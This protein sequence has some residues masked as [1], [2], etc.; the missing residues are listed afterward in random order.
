MNR[1]A[2]EF[3]SLVFRAVLAFLMFAGSSQAQAQ[4]CSDSTVA[5]TFIDWT[6]GANGGAPA[7][8]CGALN[9]CYCPALDGAPVTE[10]I[11][12]NCDAT[13]QSCTVRVSVP[14]L[15]PGNEFNDASHET[16]IY[17]FRGATPSSCTFIPNVN[18]TAISICGSVLGG[19]LGASPIETSRGTAY[20]QVS[21]SCSTVDSLAAAGFYSFNA[22]TC[23][24]NGS[25]AAASCAS[26]QACSERRLDVPSLDLTVAA[27]K[28]ALKCAIPPPDNCAEESGG[29]SLL[30]QLAGGG[31]GKRPSAGAA[32]DS[33]KDCVRTSGPA[34]CGQGIFGRGPS[35]TPQGSGPGALLRYHAN[36]VGATG[37][38]GSAA[39]K[40]RL[41]RNWSHDFAERIVIDPDVN[42]VW[43]LTRYGTFREF[44][45]TGGG[46][47]TF[48]YPVANNSPSDEYR[49]LVVTTN[50]SGG[51]TAWELKG[52]D[53]T[54]QFFRG[55]GTWDRT[56]DRN[57]NTWQ[58]HYDDAANPTKLTRVI[59]PDKRRERFEY[60]ALSGK[61]ERIFEDG[62]NLV[63]T[64]QWVYSWSGDDLVSILRPDGTSWQFFYADSS[65]PGF[66]TR[67]DLVGTD[68]TSRRIESTFE[69]DTLGNTTAL[70]R[71]EIACTGPS[72]GSPVDKLT[73]AYTNPTLPTQTVVTHFLTHDAPPVTMPVTYTIERDPRSI[74]AR[75]KSMSGDCG[76][77]GLSPNT[78]FDYN[79]PANPLK[80]TA[81]TDGNTNRTEYTYA[82]NGMTL[83]KT[84]AKGTA[85]QRTTTWTYGSANFPA[86]PTLTTSPSSDDI[87]GHLRST[88]FELDPAKG[89]LTKRTIDGYEGGVPFP[90]AVR[91]TV[92]GYDPTSG[93]L[94]SIDPP[95]F[96]AS[97]ATTTAYDEDRGSLIPLTREDPVV[98]TT[99]FVHDDWNRQIRVIDPNAVVTDTVYD[100]LNRVVS[101]AQRALDSGA[102]DA[103]DLV[104]TYHY[105]CPAGTPEDGALPCRTFRDLRC[106]QLP[107]G[108]GIEYLYDAAGRQVQI[109]RKADC[110][111]ATQPFERTVFALDVSGNRTSESFEVREGSDWIV[112]SATQNLYTTTCHVD[113]TTRGIGSASPSTTE[114][115]YDRNNNL[116]M[117]WD[118]NHPR[119]SFPSGSM[120]YEYDALDR[121][122]T[123]IQPWG[124]SGGGTSSTSYRYDSQDHLRLV[125]DANSNM[126]TYETG[127]RDLMTEESSPVFSGAANFT[128]YSYDEHGNLALKTDPRG[129][130]VVQQHDPADRMTL[131]NPPGADLDTTY[132]YDSPSVDFSKG[133]LTSISRP[134]STISYEYD[135]FGRMTKDGALAYGYDPNGNRTTIAYSPTVALCYGFDAL[136]RPVALKHT[137]TGG[138]PCAGSSLVASASYL[139]SGPLTSLAL[140]NGLTET[141]FFDDRYYPDRIQV[142]SRLD[143]DY[144]VDAVGNPTLVSDLLTPAG[145]RTYGYQ[146]YQYFLTS[147]TGP[148]A[149]LSW[150][151]DRIGNRL[152]ESQIGEP[153][154]FAYS[155]SL[156]G[157]GGRT[158]KLT[159]IQP[160]PHGNGSGVI[161]QTY[162]PAGNQITHRSTDQIA[163]PKGSGETSTL[164]YS[165]ESKL[166]RI[167]ETP[168]LAST[169]L[170]YDGRGFL[171]DALLTYPEPGAFEH[172]EPIYS[173][174][175]QLFSRR[176]RSSRSFGTPQD[177]STVGMITEDQTAYVFYF[178]GR[179]VAQLT[180][181]ASGP[182]SGLVYLTADHLGTPVLATDASG[183]TI[184]SGGFT[185]FG[186]PYQ[187]V[188]PT[189]F[190]RLPGQWTDR[191]WEG[192]GGGGIYYN[193]HRWYES[194]MGRYLAPDP[195][196]VQANPNL[197]DYAVANPLVGVD[198][199]GLLCQLSPK[200]RE[201]LTKIFGVPVD[202][203]DVYD[204]SGLVTALHGGMN[205]SRRNSIFLVSNCRSFWRSPALVLHEYNH[206]I[207]QWNRGRLSEGAYGF[208]S[209]I[210]WV[211][212]RD[213]HDD[214]KWERAAD[215]FADTHAQS[216]RE[217]V[218][219]SALPPDAPPPPPA[220][221]SRGC[222]SCS[223]H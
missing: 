126:T 56:V 146:D 219:C 57:G 171:R 12:P 53:G 10:V 209:I 20:I 109:R 221:M 46:A 192:L 28:A 92:Y 29:G 164:T 163:A 210:Q 3:R 52:L 207:D 49:Q 75:V 70:C 33:C 44:R 34:G 86:F 220:A 196:G 168:G 25:A 4:F 121:M 5:G 108:N 72:A 51:A 199:L 23:Y 162:D 137:T 58:A 97:D 205:T 83:T 187:L 139:P 55:D 2:A 87:P 148:W 150:T 26:A 211:N 93:Q 134:G 122:K 43:L 84:E 6:T 133:R 30:D 99:S 59:F 153:S 16:E 172:T 131:M 63:L 104:T 119:A 54:V 156:N 13:T 200:W 186:A 116:A 118:A 140:G 181:G 145:S 96:E 159:Q 218:G 174:S 117:V 130:T 222:G 79:D 9:R 8:N 100:S 138:D 80:P 42:H 48:A 128:T 64:R 65:H 176:W 105:D 103:A 208:E 94:A 91:E 89:N 144:T 61:L 35:C 194:G 47:G 125:I 155:Y 182:G 67:V 7:A 177:D 152:S 107:K 143:W 212:G 166:S 189:L 147:A 185:P 78:S 112:K 213:P 21:A 114:Y 77:C 206:V 14:L 215:F 197:Y 15:L 161:L 81:M 154:P 123:A 202:D 141:R 129:V 40:V 142:P 132:L 190:L 22:T 68:G 223:I 191:A 102:P 113:K 204:Y 160:R 195:L 24:I 135:R 115:C 165:A 76:S 216:L 17:W 201:C 198:P 37:M 90:S 167:A 18:C 175:G 85:E 45:K 120:T 19:V 74:K 203:I 149:G 73:F 111:P 170:L 106:I 1:P 101:V 179:P 110:D 217:C 98:G 183:A 50:G 158:P 32:G 95:G 88:A 188:P 66:L 82:A 178:A 41:G 184:W 71:G 62:V 157:T 69:Y 173:S 214:N 124:G 136:D 11:P 193:V 151:Y 60:N 38:P 169:A 27:L 39:W 180:T 127:D 36:S 31:V